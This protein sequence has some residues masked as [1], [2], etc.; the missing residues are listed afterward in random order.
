MPPRDWQVEAYRKAQSY[1]NAADPAP[2][3]I[4][5]I[6]GAGKSLLISEIAGN[7][8]LKPGEVV[9]VSTST[10][11]LVDDIQ[12]SIAHRCGRAR[13]VGWYY[14]RKKRLGDVVVAC[15]PSV[16]KLARLLEEKGRTVRLWI[17][18]ECHRTEADSVLSA[19]TTLNPDHAL[20]LTATPFRADRQETIS[21]FD[22]V[23][24]RYGVASA[25][26][27][28]VVVDWKIVH[29]QSG[30]N[31]DDV[32]CDLIREAD[33]PGLAN[34][35]GIADAEAFA[36][37]LTKHGV[38]SAAVHSKLHPRKIRRILDE[39]RDGKLHCVVH[40]NILTE[41]ANFPFLRWLCL[42]RQVG[43]R[44]RFVQE[45]GRLL[46]SHPGKDLATFY[47]PHDLFGNFRL[48]Y[49]EA[50][51][52]A[53]EKPE[54]EGPVRPAV[55]AERIADADPA[56]AV[57]Y[58]ESAIRALCVSADVVGMMGKRKILPK[59]ERLRPS[60]PIQRVSLTSGVGKVSMHAPAGWRAC[61]EQIAE[62]PHYVRFGFA[63]DLLRCIE[64][65]RARGCWPPV[66]DGGEIQAVVDTTEMLVGDGQM[67]FSAAMGAERPSAGGEK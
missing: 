6:M 5:A 28:G 24:Y 27:D 23:L 19:F 52:E 50:L 65:I 47:D 57:A 7:V 21:L 55:F 48:S 18:D 33:G 61:L 63:A 13:S 54:W 20:G 67:V 46:R 53:P 44:V 11:H 17:A 25:K 42:R 26:A 37:K 9:V 10:Q 16:A 59:V 36:Q 51:G 49:E 15:T 1:F 22:K 60:T 62:H 35:T 58:I 56:V 32:C 43:S 45:I 14:G 64:G 8:V 2:A 38:A 4:S 40:V 34:S 29:S 31:L 66:G 3:I 12:K 30:G 39:L 41:G